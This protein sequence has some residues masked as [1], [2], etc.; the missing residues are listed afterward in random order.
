MSHTYALLQ[1][2]LG[3][4]TRQ[5]QEDSYFLLTFKTAQHEEEMTSKIY[6]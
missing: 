5:Q 2:S 4:A 3:H 6:V 1:H